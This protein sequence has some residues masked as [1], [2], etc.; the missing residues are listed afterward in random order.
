MSLSGPFPFLAGLVVILAA[1]AVGL[2][3][4]AWHQAYKFTHP[5]RR[6]NPSFTPVDF[7]IPFQA[8][9]LK[10]RDGLNLSAWFIS[11][12]NPRG[13][14]IFSHGYSGDKSPD[15]EYASW[16]IEARFNLLLFDYRAHG[17]S[18]GEFTTLGFYERRDLLSAVDWLGTR[19]IGRVVVMGFSM[20]GAI[21]I[22]TAS[23]CDAIC[24]VISDSAFADLPDLIVNQMKKRGFPGII[25]D[26]FSRFILLIANV[27][28]GANFRSIVPD[29]VI[30]GISPRPVLIIHG[31][32]DDDVPVAHAR[33]LFG[34]ARD[35]KELWIVPGATHRAVDDVEPKGYRR[36][37]LAFLDKIYPGQ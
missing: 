16:L 3:L 26:L 4:V 17:D 1:L 20:G 21:G 9:S 24:G 34:A 6:D 14:I 33:K 13:T 27:Q 12:E 11:T 29:K 10:T 18:D 25:A 22:L 15:L 37:V 31:A 36:H 19:S 2:T 35:P 8:I 32:A 28:T 5:P 7:N 23:E 30:A